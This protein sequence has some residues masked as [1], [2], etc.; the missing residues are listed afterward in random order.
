MQALRFLEKVLLVLVHYVRNLKYPSIG[1]T[2]VRLAIE[3]LKASIATVGFQRVRYWI[4][5]VLSVT[6]TV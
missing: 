4:M 5:A 1:N 6:P 2:F 3:V